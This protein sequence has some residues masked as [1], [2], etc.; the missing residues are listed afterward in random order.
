LASATTKTL[1]KHSKVRPT[2]AQLETAEDKN[3]EIV[4]SV[5]VGIAFETTA[6]RRCGHWAKNVD[7][8][9]SATGSS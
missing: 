4:A 1:L 5:I 6:V 7:H 2:E 9:A 3:E 8:G